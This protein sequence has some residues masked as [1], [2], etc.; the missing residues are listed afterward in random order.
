VERHLP[1]FVCMEHVGEQCVIKHD[2]DRHMSYVVCVENE[3][4]GA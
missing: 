4:F 1:Y 2:V 3:E